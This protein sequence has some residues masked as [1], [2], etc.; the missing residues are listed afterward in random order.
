MWAY[1]RMRVSLCVVL[2]LC[3][4]GLPGC[5]VFGGKEKK[6]LGIDP[7]V[8]IEYELNIYYGSLD[9]TAKTLNY[10]L[11]ERKLNP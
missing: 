4:V 1:R 2:V 11:E 7:T 9:A 10:V 5:G 3:L 6:G 8:R